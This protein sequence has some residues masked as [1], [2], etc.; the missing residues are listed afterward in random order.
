MKINIETLKM[1]GTLRFTRLKGAEIKKKGRISRKVKSPECG[2]E[3]RRK[4][5]GLVEKYWM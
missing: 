1:R 5:K 4:R 2:K 3:V